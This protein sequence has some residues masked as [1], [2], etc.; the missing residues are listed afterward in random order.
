LA[1]TVYRTVPEP[2]PDD[3]ET[4]RIHGWLLTAVHWVSEAVGLTENEYD[5]PALG[6][7]CSVDDTQ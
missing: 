3:P 7:I 6:T 4:I 1:S 5:P 2:V